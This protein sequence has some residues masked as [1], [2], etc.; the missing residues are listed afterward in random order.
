MKNSE[1]PGC[2]RF[3]ILFHL[4]LEVIFKDSR[5]IST[6]Y[7]RMAFMFGQS[8]MNMKMMI[9][10]NVFS[11]LLAILLAHQWLKAE[12]S[13]MILHPNRFTGFIIDTRMISELMSMNTFIIFLI[14]LFFTVQR[15]TSR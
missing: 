14:I 7:A 4:N 13:A 5:R 1:K 12:L 10:K 9:L 2:I 15:R 8:L 11:I 3:L 6:V